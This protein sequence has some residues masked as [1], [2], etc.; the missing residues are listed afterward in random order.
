M[1]MTGAERVRRHRQRQTAR[2]AALELTLAN[3]KGGDAFKEMAAHANDLRVENARLRNEV[4][5]LQAA[6]RV[7]T[8]DKVGQEDSSDG[9][10]DSVDRQELA[11]WLGERPDANRRFLES[12]VKGYVRFASKKLCVHCGLNATDPHDKHTAFGRIGVV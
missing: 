6:A 10:L 5:D 12:R 11:R 7:T 2:I 4:L 1:A 8:S 3:V 9:W